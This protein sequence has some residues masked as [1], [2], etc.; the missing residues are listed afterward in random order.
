MA[1]QLRQRR[2]AHSSPGL[3]VGFLLLFSQTSLWPMH[4]SAV[5]KELFHVQTDMDP[6]PVIL[7]LLCI[8]FAQRRVSE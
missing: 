8:L 2:L 6:S 5:S 3:T 4:V 1:G 7:K